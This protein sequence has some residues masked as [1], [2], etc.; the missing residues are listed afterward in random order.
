MHGLDEKFVRF[1]EQCNEY[2]RLE[3]CFNW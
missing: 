1:Y 3:E 2:D